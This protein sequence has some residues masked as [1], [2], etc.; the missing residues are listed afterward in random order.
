MSE[1]GSGLD[2]H[3][4][5]YKKEIEEAKRR[6]F[7]KAQQEYKKAVL[8]AKKRAIER[9]KLR[10][11]QIM[12]SQE[13]YSSEM[14]ISTS[15][16]SS[17]YISAASEYSTIDPTETYEQ[18][19]YSSENIYS[20]SNSEALPS[21]ESSF[22]Y[23]AMQIEEEIESEPLSEKP[24]LIIY[25][26]DNLLLDNYERKMQTYLEIGWDRDSI[27]EFISKKENIYG[28][29]ASFNTPTVTF[30]ASS[31]RNRYYE[32][33]NRDD[34]LEHDK[35][36]KDAVR[37]IRLLSETYD[38]YI[39]SE[40]TEDL[41]DKT[42]EVMKK[43]GFPVDKINV[44]FKK[45]HDVLRTYKK[46]T[47]KDLVKKYKSGYAVIIHPQDAIIF[48]TLAITPIG[49]T[50]IRDKEEFEG[51]TEYICDSWT[52]IIPILYRG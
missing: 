48:D 27:N 47:V 42:L 5:L 4:E 38:I 13:S 25:D 51:E 49:L 29:I 9:A 22:D 3:D 6:I 45:M 36:Y 43:L 26:L 21:V 37:A 46:N 23:G 34:M 14:N 12:G 44:I 8:E 31:R 35:P 30:T 16:D 40:R 20:H 18:T 28:K 32:I 24:I 2:W 1:D 41:K 19:S 17:S 39:I 52:Q 15:T 50:T 33:Y 10:Y 11:Q 7:A